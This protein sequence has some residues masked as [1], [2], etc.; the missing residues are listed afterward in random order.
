MSFWD[1]RFCIINT[2][3]PLKFPSGSVDTGRGGEGEGAIS[4]S[5]V[6]IDVIVK[7][8]KL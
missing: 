2:P 3:K 7:F 6:V 4:R 8:G 1:N 5:V